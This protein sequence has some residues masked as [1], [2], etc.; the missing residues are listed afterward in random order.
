MASFSSAFKLQVKYMSDISK[1]GLF[2]GFT[3]KK[4][5]LAAELR[6]NRIRLGAYYILRGRISNV[7]GGKRE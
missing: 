4:N 6:P 1:I 5:N 3:H 2:G 7:T